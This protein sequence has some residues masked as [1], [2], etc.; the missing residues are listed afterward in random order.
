M[1]KRQTE[2]LHKL[3]VPEAAARIYLSLLERGPETISDLARR[4]GL[5]RPIIYKYLPY[6]VSKSLVS[7]SR[8]GKRT[9]YTA[10]EPSVLKKLIDSLEKEFAEELPEFLE[11]YERKKDQPVIRF[12]EG[13]RGIRYIYEYLVRTAKPSETLYRYESP[14]NFTINKR[15]YPSLYRQK[16][17]GLHPFERFV[18]T[19]ERTHL[20][21]RQRLERHSRAVPAEYDKFEY[22]ITELILGGKVAFID[23]GSETASLIEDSTFADFQRQLFLLLFRKLG[24][25]R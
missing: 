11:T 1:K 21:R 24:P 8:E 23:Y 4:T 17:D 14:K 10:E 3:G 20:A 18:I 2:L 15:Y 9:I 19:N 22:N 7:T 13:K 5:H 25:S 16:E 12:F 6:L